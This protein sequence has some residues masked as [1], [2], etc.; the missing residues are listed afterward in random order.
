M[1]VSTTVPP[2]PSPR[3]PTFLSLGCPSCSLLAAAPNPSLTAPRLLC[4]DAEITPQLATVEACCSQNTDSVTALEDRATDLEAANSQ[5]TAQLSTANS[6]LT[7]MSDLVAPL[8]NTNLTALAALNLTTIQAVR[9]GAQWTAPF[10]GRPAT[11]I[12]ESLKNR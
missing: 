9:D 10:Q 1:R 8:R 12:N 6:Q 11:P 3:L 5:L 2:P 7:A 4:P